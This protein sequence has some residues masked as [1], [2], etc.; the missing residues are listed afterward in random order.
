MAS[1]SPS[2]KDAIRLRRSFPICVLRLIPSST[3]A[4][5]FP[6]FSHHSRRACTWSTRRER[7]SIFSAQMMS[8]SSA[9]DSSTAIRCSIALTSFPMV[10][11]SHL[12][13]SG[14]FHGSTPP[15]TSMSSTHPTTTCPS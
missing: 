1:S 8:Y 4:T 12:P 10:E 3:V 13:N 5:S 7:R 14:R 11:G 9:R 2:A 15:D 6:F